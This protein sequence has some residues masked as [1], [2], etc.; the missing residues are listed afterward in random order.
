M[1][2]RLAAAPDL[3]EAQELAPMAAVD[4]P[5]QADLLHQNFRQSR[6]T[7]QRAA[8]RERDRLCAHVATEF[9]PSLN[10]V[11]RPPRFL[12]SLLSRFA[13]TL[14]VRLLAVRVA[15]FSNVR[16]RFTRAQIL[17]RLLRERA[18]VSA[19]AVQVLVVELL[20]IEQ[21]QVRAVDRVVC[22]RGGL[23]FVFLFILKSRRFSY[24][25]VLN[26][27]IFGIL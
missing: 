21:R 9:S 3:Q 1:R 6:R 12:R 15:H 20:E 5:L 25:S 18:I 13:P 14:R 10:N 7:L 22:S 11:N 17:A 26:V 27:A 23:T 16:I 2:F 24:H 19:D 4:Y 8:M